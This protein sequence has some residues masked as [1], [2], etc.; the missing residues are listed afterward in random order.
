MPNNK[1]TKQSVATKQ[2]FEKGRVQKEM[3]ADKA[4]PHCPIC[5]KYTDKKT[6]PQCFGHGGGGVGSS[7]GGG[8]SDQKAVKDDAKPQAKPVGN[9]DQGSHVQAA[10]VIVTSHTPTK[11]FEKK[12]ERFNREVISDLL[13]KNILSI[14]NDREKG[15]LTIKLLCDVSVLSSE[16]KAELKKFVNNILNELNEFKK[17][18]GLSADCYTLKKDKDGNILSLQITLPTPTL[19]DAFIQ[20]LASKHILPLQNVAH[21][22]NEKIVYPEGVNLFESTPLS[23]KPTPGNKKLID[24]EIEENSKIKSSIRPKSPLDGLKPKGGK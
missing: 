12:D 15:I 11:H 5:G 20:R 24:K 8:G 4:K 17:E 10:S 18:N 13:S 22:K 9:V 3:A 23:T 6:S 7:S 1:I 14:D 2:Q 19:Y 21:N 16:H